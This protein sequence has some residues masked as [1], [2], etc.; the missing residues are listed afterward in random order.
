[1][2]FTAFVIQ[3]LARTVR[4][5]GRRG[6]RAADV[7]HALHVGLVHLVQASEFRHGFAFVHSSAKRNSQH[8]HHGRIS[9]ILSVCPIVCCSDVGCD[10]SGTFSDDLCALFGW[11]GRRQMG[12]IQIHDFSP[13]F[14]VLLHV[15]AAISLIRRVHGPPKCIRSF[16]SS[17][18]YVSGCL[19]SLGCRFGPQDSSGRIV[20]GRQLS[21]AAA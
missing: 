9:S 16:V 2:L 5:C 3:L 12:K 10:V 17:V 1:L 11:F 15:F 8:H 20:H 18:R 6:A 7:E 19:L 14:F 21:R 13:R 4:T